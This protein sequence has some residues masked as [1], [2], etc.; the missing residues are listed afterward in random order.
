MYGVNRRR[1]DDGG[2]SHDVGV[3]CFAA[4]FKFKEEDDSADACVGIK[5][6]NKKPPRVAA[7]R[8]RADDHEDVRLNGSSIR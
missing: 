4:R 1:S 7:K 3:Y 2:G 5:D 8:T 6:D